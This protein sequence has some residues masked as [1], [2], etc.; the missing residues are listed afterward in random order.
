M[1]KT[2]TRRHFLQRATL[3]SLGTAAASGAAFG[4]TKAEARRKRADPGGD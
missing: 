1:M 2:N 3:L 4:Q